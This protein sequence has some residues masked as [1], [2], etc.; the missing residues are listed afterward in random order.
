MTVH[1]YIA[2]YEVVE[3]ARE[4]CIEIAIPFVFEIRIETIKV[5]VQHDCVD[6]PER[7]FTGGK[8]AIRVAACA[9]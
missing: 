4:T 8:I 5:V 9:V 2:V 1:I 3:W 6:A 7:F